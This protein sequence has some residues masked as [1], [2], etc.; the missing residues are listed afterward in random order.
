MRLTDINL[1]RST[2]VLS[3]YN[4]S[5]RPTA[6]EVLTSYLEQCNEPPWTSYFVKVFF[7]HLHNT[8]RFWSQTSICCTSTYQI[9]T[10]TNTNWGHRTRLQP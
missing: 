3:I 9:M 6:S 2:Q 8:A 5:S 1:L 10:F 4:F 7:C